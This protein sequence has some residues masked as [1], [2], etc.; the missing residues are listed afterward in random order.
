MDD[1][2]E[3]ALCMGSS[4]FVRGNKDLLEALELLIKSRGWE[5]RVV[6]SGMN[7]QD[8][9]TAGPNVKINGQLHQG[10]DEGAVKDLLLE[11]IGGATTVRMSSV[12]RT[13]KN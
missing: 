5:D 10:L 2:I 13:I 4:C 7:C 8:K 1:R 11:K 9:C 3:I 6:L 12:R